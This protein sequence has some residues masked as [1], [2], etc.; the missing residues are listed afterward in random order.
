MPTT[1]VRVRTHPKDLLEEGMFDTLVAR[2]HKDHPDLPLTTCARIQQQAVEFLDACGR[3]PGTSLTPSGMVDLGWHNLI[4]HTETYAKLCHDL[5]GEFIHHHPY[6]GN[7]GN[8]AVLARTQEL[9]AAAGHTVDRELWALNAD[10][11]NDA[12]CGSHA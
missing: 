8:P 4:L 2:L 9:I 12:P 3:N 5:R 6:D 11:G 10:C 7:Q 1:D